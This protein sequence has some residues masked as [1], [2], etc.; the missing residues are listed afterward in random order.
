MSQDLSARL[1]SLP[2]ALLHDHLDGSLRLSTL[3]ACC[4]AQGIEPPAPDVPGLRRWFE[5]NA[6]AGSLERYL[7]GFGLTVAALASP[8]ALAQV[9]F[10]AAEDARAEGCVLAEL[11]MA[12]LLLEPLGVSPD[13]AVQ[14]M[15][16]GLSR[17]PLPTGLIVCG[18]RHESPERVRRA[19]DLALRHRAT[20]ARQPGVV[21]F[22]LAGPERG[23]PATLH[24]HTLEHVVAQGLPLTLHAGEADEGQRVL[25]AVRLGARRIGHGVRLADLLDGPQAPEILDELRQRQVHLEICPTSNVQTGAA[26]SIVEH[27]IRRLWAAGVSLSFHTDNRLISCTS[28]VREARLLVEQAGF[29]LADLGRMQQQALQASFLEE[30]VRTQGLAALSAWQTQVPPEAPTR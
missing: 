26:A 15:L 4:R 10:E 24:R 14:A 25:E 5:A 7:E 3:L 2:K 28:L 18:M 16:E 27:P 22:D 21:G 11:R 20:S 6:M 30:P 13:Q 8:Q 29:T 23:F 17:S 9:A 12:P 19:A 1:D